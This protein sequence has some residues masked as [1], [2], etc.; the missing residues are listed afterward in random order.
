MSARQ[1]TASPTADPILTLSDEAIAEEVRR[2]LH[3][4][5]ATSH[6]TIAVRVAE[7][8]VRLRGV[9]RRVADAD[10]AEAVAGR[11]QEA[12][13]VINELLIASEQ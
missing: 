1:R 10:S 5:V 13:G 2:V 4:D 6:L 9:V 3:E 12:R 11:V 8:V 7:G